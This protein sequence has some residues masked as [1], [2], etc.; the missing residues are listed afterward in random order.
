MTTRP[1][2]GRGWF[3]AGTLL[4][5]LDITGG[6]QIVVP[7]T[8]AMVRAAARMAESELARAL[9]T[10]GRDTPRSSHTGIALS[11]QGL[12]RNDALLTVDDGRGASRTLRLSPR[13]SEIA[14]NHD[15]ELIGVL[16]NL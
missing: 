8:M 14:V 6:E 15:D 4:G 2:P 10:R 7:Q 16:G 5:V 11:L 13:H 3:L 9:L 1:V 12:G